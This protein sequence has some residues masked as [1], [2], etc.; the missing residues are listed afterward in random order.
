MRM[1]FRVS[2]KAVG[3]E[4]RYDFLRRKLSL[5]VEASAERSQ[6]HNAATDKPHPQKAYA[7]PKLAVCP[8]TGERAPPSNSAFKRPSPPRASVPVQ[9]RGTL[10]QPAL[11]SYGEAV[12]QTS[13]NRRLHTKS[14]SPMVRSS[15]RAQV[16]T[17]TIAHDRH[18]SRASSAVAP[19]TQTP[20]YGYTRVT[21][22]G[23]PSF[24]QFDRLHPA[25]V[26]QRTSSPHLIKA[27]HLAREQTDGRRSRT[28]CPSPQREQRLS[29]GSDLESETSRRRHRSQSPASILNRAHNENKYGQVRVRSHSS[30]RYLAVEDPLKNQKKR[31]NSVDLDLLSPVDNTC[32][33]PVCHSYKNRH[34]LDLKKK[35]KG[36]ST[37]TTSTSEYTRRPHRKHGMNSQLSQS[38]EYLSQNLYKPLLEEDEE[39]FKPRLHAS[40]Y[41]EEQ[42]ER[43]LPRASADSGY[44]SPIEHFGQKEISPFRYGSKVSNRTL[45]I[46]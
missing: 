31:S 22:C 5:R 35:F 7:V 4:S 37:Y 39:V 13:S 1:S 2:S 17:E 27:P 18:W 14:V 36:G 42:V 45:Q 28:V 41:K 20:S 38:T 6:R 32:G 19:S 46:P 26:S 16:T 8:E 21:S 25:L 9:C 10:S 15:G 30:E 11:T 34:D 44:T 12:S 24:S 3:K 43:K 23:R 33:R 29:V 40:S